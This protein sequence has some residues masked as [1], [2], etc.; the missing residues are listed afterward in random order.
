MLVKNFQSFCRR[1]VIYFYHLVYFG[2]GS[3]FFNK[4]LD[5]KGSISVLICCFSDSFNSCHSI[6]V[7]QNN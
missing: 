2:N 7:L 6:L 5:L 1:A 4:G 3:P